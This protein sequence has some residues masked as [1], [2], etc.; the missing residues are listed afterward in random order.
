MSGPVIDLRTYRLVPGGREEFDRIF[1]ED[2]RPMLERR[3]IEVVGHGPSLSDDRHYF[4]ARGFP[5][6]AERDRQLTSFY[7]SAEWKPHDDRVMT[8]VESLHHLVIPW[9]G[10]AG[11]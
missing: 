7:G 9:D 8:L 10:D 6:E 2:V 5:S 4:L 11:L 3:G 1:R